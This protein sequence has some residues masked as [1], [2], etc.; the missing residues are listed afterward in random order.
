MPRRVD[1]GQSSDV[2]WVV[3]ADPEGNEFCI[4][5]ALTPEEQTVV[6]VD[7]DDDLAGLRAGRPCRRRGT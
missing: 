1:V 3:F 5:R 4:L 6:T 2:S 7:H